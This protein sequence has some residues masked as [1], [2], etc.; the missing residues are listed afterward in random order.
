MTTTANFY[1]QSI[2]KKRPGEKSE[3]AKIIPAFNY[4]KG[5]TP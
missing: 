1:H 4:A 2:E 3:P 5:Y